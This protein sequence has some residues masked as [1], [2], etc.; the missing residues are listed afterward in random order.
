MPRKPR[1]CPA[2][3]A[4]HIIQRGNNRQVCFGDESDFA[5]Y[6]HWLRE[7]AKRWGDG[8]ACVGVDDEPR[9]SACDTGSIACG[10]RDDAVPRSSVR[11]PFQLSMATQR[12]AVGGALQGV[13]RAGYGI[14]SAL[15]PHSADPRRRMC[16]APARAVEFR[17]CRTAWRP[18]AVFAMRDAARHL[19]GT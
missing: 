15:L 18:A 13:S 17:P 9:A 1:V 5:A 12:D 11:A 4:R 2:G 6:A 7:A 19:P 14:S 16:P 8:A 10:I 3:G